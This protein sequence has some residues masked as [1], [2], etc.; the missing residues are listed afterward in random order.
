MLEKKNLIEIIL[1]DDNPNDAELAIRALKKHNMANKMVHLKDGAEALEFIFGKN[2]S[3][4]TLIVQPKLIL[5]DIKMP[6]V[7]GIEVLRK[8]KSDPRT[9]KIP[10]VVMTSSQEGKD[11][12]ES[13][14]LGVNAYV[15][16][17]LDFHEFVN[18]VRE[19]GLFWILINKIPEQT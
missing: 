15:V 3:A 17:P 12:V 2:N 5:L 6:K 10:V 19:I 9:K 18:T 11:M 8:L 1:V 4:E 14:N 16:K 7:D 13:Y